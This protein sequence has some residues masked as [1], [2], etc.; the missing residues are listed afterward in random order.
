MKLEELLA[1]IKI[2]LRLRNFS[3]KTIKGY[4]SCLGS[5]FRYVKAVSDQPDVVLIKEYLL[6]MFDEDRSSITVNAHL[7]Y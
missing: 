5:Y 7:R 6:K 3:S 2:E 4:L 1:K